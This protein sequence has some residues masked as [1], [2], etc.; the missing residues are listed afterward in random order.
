MPRSSFWPLSATSAAVLSGLVVAFAVAAS[1]RA[2]PTLGFVDYDDPLTVLAPPLRNGLTSEAFRFAFAGTAANLWQPLS[3][4]SH[5]LDTQ[6]YGSWAGGHHLTNVLLHLGS[7]LILLAWLR[8]HTGEGLLALAVAL[9]FAIHPLRVES[10]AWVTERKDVLSLLF[11]LLAIWF[12][13]SWAASS[14]P[15][16]RRPY[17]LAVL[18]AAIGVLCKPSLMTLPA[19]L[20]LVDV[21]PLRRLSWDDRGNLALL[22][23][24]LVEKIPF[25]LL[26]LAAATIAWVTWSGGQLIGEAKD[27]SPV[28]RIGYAGLAYLSYLLRTAWPVDLVP[29]TSYPE[30]DGLVLGLILAPIAL[31]AATLAALL[32]HRRSPW[33]TVGW[34]WF[35][36]AILPGSGL[37]TISDHFAPDRYTYLA[38]VGLFTALA[39]ETAALVRRSRAAAAAALLALAAAL[40]ALSLLTDRQTRVWSNPETLWRHALAAGGPNYVA[41]NQ[42]GL[43]LLGQGRHEEGVAELRRSIAANPSFAVSTR[44]L[45][46]AMAAK[47]DLLEAARLLREAGPDL[48]GHESYQEALLRASIAAG[49]DEAAAEIWRSIAA[50]RPE[51]RESQLGA[52]AFLYGIGKEDEALA[53]YLAAA[54]LDPNDS[55][56]L[57][58]LGALLLKRGNTT[59]ALPW[60]ERALATSR[61]AA[62]SAGARR[63]LG[64]AKILERE[65]AAAIDHYGKGLELMPDDP[66]LLNE[67]AQLLLDCPE[68][69]LRDATRAVGL[70][71]ALVAAERERGAARVNPRFLRTL[72]RGLAAVGRAEEA[73]ATALAGLEAVEEIASQ[74]PLEKP[75][76][77]EELERLR[78]WFQEQAKTP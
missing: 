56:T 21:W 52:A 26:A 23:A 48:P 5:A 44:N 63:T 10:V 61:G 35:L 57:R 38:H 9:L 11:Y 8:R 53:R 15:R 66:L 60:L 7:A 78:T 17:L 43:H 65:W 1:F 16:R 39:W 47:G 34:L 73:T 13:S 51:D 29:Y 37:I 4:L 77:P 28:L 2:A 46:N 64:Q 12:Y 75:W 69:S 70:A 41:H 59:E 33:I 27:L 58:S 6:I 76:T 74:E 18:S 25:A 14:E 72:A 22:K 62:Q 32:L 20:L 49:N 3:S 30:P 71:E 55:E 50:E 45:S 24:R 19:V 42:L 67:L 68:R 54:R 31:A 36:A 40:A